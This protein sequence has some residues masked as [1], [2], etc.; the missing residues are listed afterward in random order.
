MVF[1]NGLY[2]IWQAN[3]AALFNTDEIQ[4]ALQQ[5]AAG[6]IN[7]IEYFESIDSTNAYLMQADTA[8]HGC[9][10]IADYQTE[11]KGRSGKQW[12]SAAGTNLLFSLGWSP[13]KSPGAAVSLVVAVAVADALRQNGLDNVGLKWPNDVL[14]EG[15][16]LAGVL[17]E[18]RIRGA[19]IALVIGVGLNLKNN[20]ALLSDVTQPWVDLEQLGMGDIQR[21]VLL[22]DILVSLSNR[23]RQLET[24][25]FAQIRDDWLAYHA[26][27]GATVSYEFEGGI[28]YGVITG[29]N[30]LGALLLASNG[31]VKALCAGE[32]HHV[33]LKS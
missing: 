2:G 14:V 17:L 24:E 23:F 13:R 11:G 33:R 12:L 3:F 6:W 9:V 31:E 26:L 28:Q 29:L 30:P 10:C 25:G 27:N 18:S 22:I 5:K 15:A 32:I 4:T 16:K 1:I 20:P 21:Q 7:H 8:V 19:Q